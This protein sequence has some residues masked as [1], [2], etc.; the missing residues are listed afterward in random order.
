MLHAF[1]SVPALNKFHAEKLPKTKTKT[2]VMHFNLKKGSGSGGKST[3]GIESTS[4]APSK[5]LTE[6]HDPNYEP[7]KEEVDE[8]AVWLGMDLVKDQHFRWIATQGLKRPMLPGWKPCKTPDTGEIYYFN[9]KTGESSWDH[10]C[11]FYDKNL[12]LEEKRKRDANKKKEAN[13]KEK[14]ATTIAKE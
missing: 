1:A 7:T 8:Y 12:L 11:D 13:E 14:D 5:I 10:P 3:Q 2:V 6:K 4:T 9:F